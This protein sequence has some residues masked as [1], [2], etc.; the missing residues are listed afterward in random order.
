MYYNEYIPIRKRENKMTRLIYVVSDEKGGVVFVGTLT[1]T[2][3]WMK[4]EEVKFCP[5]LQCYAKFASDKIL[6]FF[7][8]T[9]TELNST[10]AR[11]VI[12]INGQ[13]MDKGQLKG[14]ETFFPDLAEKYNMFEDEHIHTIVNEE[15]ECTHIVFET[16]IGEVSITLPFK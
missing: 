1:N 6:Y 11:M 15:E 5:N 3:Q 8:I 13:T 12:L 16:T 4:K 7:H 2:L 10:N 14:E 9:E